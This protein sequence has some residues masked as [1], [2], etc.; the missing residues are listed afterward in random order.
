MVGGQTACLLLLAE[1]PSLGGAPVSW[2]ARGEAIFLLDWLY[3]RTWRHGHRGSGAQVLRFRSPWRG[4]NGI[5]RMAALM[6]RKKGELTK[7]LVT[8]RWGRAA[9]TCGTATAIFLS[10]IFLSFTI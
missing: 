4:R 6:T 7:T 10:V 9:P 8:E 1:T 2:S 3:R 5:G